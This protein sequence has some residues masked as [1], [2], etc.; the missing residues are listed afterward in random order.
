M[1]YKNYAN[2]KKWFHRFHFNPHYASQ[3]NCSQIYIAGFWQREKKRYFEVLK[4][5]KPTHT[6]GMVQGMKSNKKICPADH[7]YLRTDV[8]R[9]CRN[10]S[11]YYYGTGW[12]KGDPNYRGEMYVNGQKCSPQKFNDARLLLEDCRFVW[13]LENCHDDHYSVNYMTEKI[14]HGFLSGGIPIYCGAWNIDQIIDPELFI[15]LRKFNYNIKDVCDFCE[16]MSDEEYRRRLD[17]I[18]NFMNDGANKFSCDFRFQE[19][20]LKLS[21]M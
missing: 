14:F 8:V 7:G 10:R 6:F 18:Y 12:P 11:F 9:E 3:P 16:K 13:C 20:D 15:D 1:E 19:L 4:E 2:D 17:L 21:S 5:Q